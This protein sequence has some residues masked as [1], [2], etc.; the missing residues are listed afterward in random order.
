[1]CHIA[2]KLNKGLATAEVVDCY[3]PAVIDGNE[4]VVNTTITG[5]Q[6]LATALD[7][8]EG[9][10]SWVD[11]GEANNKDFDAA[12]AHKASANDDG[13]EGA[14]DEVVDVMLKSEASYTSGSNF[15]V[16]S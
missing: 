1:M 15:N 11:P 2:H 9:S 13:L 12:A 4:D 14:G 7:N 8:G 5:N 10:N 6:A 16:W 3:V